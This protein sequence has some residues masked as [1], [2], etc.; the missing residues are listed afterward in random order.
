MQ[1]VLRLNEGTQGRI[2]ACD[3]GMAFISTG[4]HLKFAQ[5]TE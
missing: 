1:A 2:S 4:Y 5:S 3:V